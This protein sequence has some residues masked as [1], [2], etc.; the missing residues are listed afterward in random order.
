[1]REVF[2]YLFSVPRLSR[3][4]SQLLRLGRAGPS[5]GNSEKK[6]R[7]RL[8]RGRL[9]KLTVIL[10]CRAQQSRSGVIRGGNEMIGNGVAFN[11]DGYF[12]MA[13]KVFRR[14]GGGG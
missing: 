8:L 14:Q 12:A 9:S 4:N 3:Q 5:Y 11:G 2:D 6:I 1:M 7:R 13:P 10:K